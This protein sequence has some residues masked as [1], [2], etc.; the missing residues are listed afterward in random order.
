MNRKL[1]FDS[2][3]AP[4]TVTFCAKIPQISLLWGE[5]CTSPQK[6]SIQNGAEFTNVVNLISWKR[7]GQLID[8]NVHD[9][10]MLLDEWNRM[11]VPV[12]H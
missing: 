6:G 8:L 1:R 5:F 2:E 7:V 9:R 11:G 4:K 10:G 12:G 3:K